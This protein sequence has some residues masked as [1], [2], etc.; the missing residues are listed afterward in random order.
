MT[1]QEWLACTDPKAM[2]AVL[3]GNVSQRKLRLF[4]LACCRRMWHLLPNGRWGLLVE[5]GERF[6]DG[7]ASRTELNTAWWRVPTAFVYEGPDYLAVVSD[8]IG[9]VD[10]TPQKAQEVAYAA[11]KE[12]ARDADEAVDAE[13]P[14]CPRRD[15]EC[16]AQAHLLRDIF[17]PFRPVTAPPALR[18]PEAVALAQAA[19]DQR[20]LPAGVLDVARLAVLAD[21]LEDAGCDQA[22]LLA[23]L[24]GAGPH[25]RGC[26]AVDLLLGKG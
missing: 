1:E 14:R 22:D 25:V 21:A 12:V 7:A 11:A 9:C 3:Q 5:V 26:W 2:L 23:H 13:A 4:G 16:A 18:T 10:Y 24:R 8:K 17:N 15:A 6:V 19:Y 20:E